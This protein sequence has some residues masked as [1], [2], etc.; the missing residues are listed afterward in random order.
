MINWLSIFAGCCYIALGIFVIIEKSFIVTELHP[1]VATSL[2]A[3]I[4]V[5]GLFRIIRAIVR[6]KQDHE[7]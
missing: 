1:V 7:E 5:Y 3:L 4:I 6:L 2:G